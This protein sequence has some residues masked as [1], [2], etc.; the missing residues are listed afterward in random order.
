MKIIMGV[1]DKMVFDGIKGFKIVI[2]KDGFNESVHGTKRYRLYI[3]E[4]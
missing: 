4:K 3:E 2:E 1:K